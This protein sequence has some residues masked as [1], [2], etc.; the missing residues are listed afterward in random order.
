MNKLSQIKV[1]EKAIN[2]EMYRTGSEEND[3]CNEDG[4]KWE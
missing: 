3:R 1:H 2:K 4:E